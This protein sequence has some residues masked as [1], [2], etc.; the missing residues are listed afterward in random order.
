ME[1]LEIVLFLYVYKSQE[2][3]SFISNTMFRKT[4][5]VVTVRQIRTKT[6]RGMDPLPGE[7]IIKTVLPSF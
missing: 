4:P 5:T 3:I 1:Q 6:L 7:V 2:V